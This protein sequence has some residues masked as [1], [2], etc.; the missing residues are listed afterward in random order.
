MTHFWFIVVLVAAVVLCIGLAVY[1]YF[2]C[3]LYEEE[4]R[5]YTGG[6]NDGPDPKEDRV[7][8]ARLQ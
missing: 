2:E 8:A 1:V 7:K 4:L 3:K 5:R 6:F